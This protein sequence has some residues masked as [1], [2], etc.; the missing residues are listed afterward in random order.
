M[1]TILGLNLTSTNDSVVEIGGDLYVKTPEALETLLRELRDVGYQIDNL[2]ESTDRLEHNMSV[3]E[4]EA[5]GL[6]LWFAKLDIRRGKCGSCGGIISIRGIRVHN[7]K[8]ELCGAVTY[9]EIVDG[10]IVRFKF[11]SATSSH[12]TTIRLLA[13]HWDAEEGYLYLYPGTLLGGFN[14]T[15]HDAAAYM[16]AHKELWENVTVDGLEL[17]KVRYIRGL[18]NDGSSAIEP[19]NISGS[20]YNHRIVNVWDGKEYDEFFSNLPVRDMIS[21]Y[22]AWHW[23]PLPITRT[24]HERILSAAGQVSDKGYYY[25]DGRPAFDERH[26]RRM[27]AFVRHFTSLD[28]DAFDRAWPRF[29]RDGPG[30]IDDLAAFCHPDAHVE[31]RPNIGNVLTAIGKR[32]AGRPLTNEELAAAVRGLQDPRSKVLKHLI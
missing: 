24:L 11:R 23:S 10:S 9:Q 5:R 29:R 17:I 4:M 28:A 16:D 32:N 21:I 27:A 26:W 25:Q 12:R 31:D 7:H 22:E 3:A 14:L 15:G 8:C 13:H 20:V 19:Y 6:S 30:G 18:Q 1:P 2:R